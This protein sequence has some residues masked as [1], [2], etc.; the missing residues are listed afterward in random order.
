VLLSECKKNNY[1]RALL[2]IEMAPSRE[3]NPE[4][5]EALL[6]DTAELLKEVERKE[7]LLL[8]SFEEM[9][10]DEFDTPAYYHVPPKP[11]LVSRSANSVTVAIHPFK[12]VGRGHSAP[13][14]PAIHHVKLFGKPAG[15]GTDVSLNNTSFP[16]TGVAV[17][18]D[19]ATHSC[20]HMTV[21]SLPSNDSYVF[22]VVAFDADGEVISGVG[23]MC[24]PIEALNPLPLPLVWSYLAQRALDLGCPSIAEECSYVV[25]DNCISRAGEAFHSNLNRG[26]EANPMH[27][28]TLKPSIVDRLSDA[29]QQ[30]FCKSCCVYVHTA[31]VGVGGRSG[32]NLGLSGGDPP[33]VR[34][35]PATRKLLRTRPP[36]LTSGGR[37]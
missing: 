35:R 12:L 32:Q 2:Q 3:G 29:M 36:V 4:E 27:G 22:A 28:L 15:A 13:P 5:M 25:L 31:E 34:G 8:L 30:A 10:S 37:L 24:A 18:Y 14:L 16:G 11:L 19:A 1:Q 17:P 20:P 9:A 23:E 21:T 26:W 33:P 7:T 6:R